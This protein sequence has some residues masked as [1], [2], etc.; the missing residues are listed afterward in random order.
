MILAQSKFWRAQ[1][2]KS[3]AHV[4]LSIL[5]D[6]LP[7]E[8]DEVKDLR[9]ELPLSEWQRVVKQLRGDRKLLGGI[10]LD[11]ARTKEQLPLAIANDRLLNGLQSVAAEA[12]LALVEEGLLRLV[13][14][15]PE[16]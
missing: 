9:I 13:P 7:A 8:L 6:A 4:V 11:F 2:G 5:K 15:E 1:L 10:L 12:T 16:E 3:G 14:I